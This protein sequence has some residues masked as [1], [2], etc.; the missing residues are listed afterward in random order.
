MGIVGLWDWL[1]IV[2]PNAF[3]QPVSQSSHHL[4]VDLPHIAFATKSQVRSRMNPL[5]SMEVVLAS[6]N[7]LI[8]AAKPLKSVHIAFDG[9]QPIAK[10]F[11]HGRQREHVRRTPKMGVEHLMEQSDLECAIRRKFGHLKLSVNGARNPGEGEIKVIEQL[12]RI[13]SDTNG[14]DSFTIVSGDGDLVPQLFLLA[15]KSDTLILRHSLL[16]NTNGCFVLQHALADIMRQFP[17]SEATRVMND[18]ALLSIMN[19][20]DYLYAW[21]G[22]NM[23]RLFDT[24]ILSQKGFLVDLTSD[25]ISFNL[26]AIH[27][28]LVTHLPSTTRSSA[29]SQHA[30]RNVKLY[31][32]ALKW[33]LE[34]YQFAKCPDYSFS[35]AP[36]SRSSPSDMLYG[37]LEWMDEL[38]STRWTGPWQSKTVLELF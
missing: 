21:P 25:A 2:S 8:N 23:A 4:L 1:K 35:V 16:Q 24:Y 18:L 31:F 20:N 29:K 34:M 26:A 11:C 3:R 6:L 32:K 30:L 10:Q 28:L 37:L 13:Y 22:L 14:K 5:Q 33:N 19:G 36:D 9:I 7:G 27:H 38:K 12:T 17:N 15:P